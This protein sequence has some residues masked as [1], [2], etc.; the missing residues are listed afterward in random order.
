MPRWSWRSYAL[1]W[2]GPVK[3]DQSVGLWLISPGLNRFITLVRILL[4]LLFAALLLAGTPSLRP[5]SSAPVTVGVALALCVLTSAAGASAEEARTPPDRALLEELKHR[6]TRPEPCQPSCIST[7]AL[8]LRLDGGAL[9]FEA[10]VHAADTGAW[11]IP[12]PP[13]SWAPAVVRVDGQA[14]SALA[15]LDDGF[16]YVRLSPG[17]HR[18]EASGPAPR[19]DTLTVQLRDR[20]HRATAD[21]SGWDVSGLR[22]DAPPD[23]S[24]Q[25]NRRLRAGERAREESGQYAPWL[26][27][28]RTLSL[29]LTWRVRTDV[30]RVSPTGVPVSLRVPLIEGEAPTEPDL[31]IKDG[32][33]VIALGRDQTETGWSS[34]L[35]VT[36]ALRLKAA[37]GQPW[38]EVWSLEC[39]LIWECEATGLAPVT[40]QSGGTLAPEFRP[41]P[42][43]TL[44]LTFRH[45][46]A[47]VGQTVTLEAVRVETTPGERLTTTVL[48]L[49]ARASREEPL[50]LTLPT[51]AEVQEVTVGGTSRPG[52]ADQG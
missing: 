20:P 38:S 25:L 17:V 30:R 12:G 21:A 9:A 10:E 34:T 28:R 50:V 14:T 8:H 18:V 36:E 11:A 24:I 37:E 51:D 3:A 2:T 5:M 35:P 19:S 42:G 13:A 43:E 47:V 7:S 6:I 23:T 40:H 16:L 1:G 31:E 27:V 26:E 4:V 49:T 15:R 29:G 33:A 48:S 32:S 46:Q 39:G 22:A 41:W 44:A 45:P 52:H